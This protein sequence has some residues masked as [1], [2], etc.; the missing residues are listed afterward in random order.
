MNFYSFLNFI[1]LHFV[2]HVLFYCINL[3]AVFILTPLTHVIIT[4]R[5]VEF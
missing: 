2:C 5:S 3:S 1:L 4:S